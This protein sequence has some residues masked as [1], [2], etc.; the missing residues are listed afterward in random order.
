MIYF[1][2]SIY[3]NKLHDC[4]NVFFC[5]HPNISAHTKTSGRYPHL[6]AT[7]VCKPA[8]IA[9]RNGKQGQLK[10]NHFF[11]DIARNM[12]PASISFASSESCVANSFELQPYTSMDS[13]MRDEDGDTVRNTLLHKIKTHSASS[14]RVRARS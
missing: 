9:S 1:L 14:T 2:P 5:L 11:I 7:Y 6:G 8:L 4:K 10:K 12:V 13:F 3:L